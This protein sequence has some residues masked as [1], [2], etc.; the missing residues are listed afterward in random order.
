MWNNMCLK[1]IKILKSW[2]RFETPEAGWGNEKFYEK[3]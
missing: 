2:P 3:L 1:D